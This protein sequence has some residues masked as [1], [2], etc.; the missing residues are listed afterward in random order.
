MDAAWLIGRGR[1]GNVAQLAD[2][3][4]QPGKNPAAR[5]SQLHRK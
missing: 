5:R 2:A 3:L 4:D 1:M